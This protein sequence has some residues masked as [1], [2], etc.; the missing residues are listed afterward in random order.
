M[1]KNQKI[2]TIQQQNYLETVYDLSLEA[3]H[4]HVKDIAA[5]LSKSMP[6]VTEAMRKL[7]K[8]GYVNYDIRRNI[9]LTELGIKIG[10]ELAE[11]HNILADFYSKILG[12]PYARAQKIACKVEHVVDKKFCSRLAGFAKF[13]LSC[14]K[15]NRKLVKEFHDYYNRP[16]Y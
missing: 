11:R 14:E 8:K 2:L 13:I 1:N 5:K 15:E 16:N 6:S 12:C 4:T 9:T 7:A 10:K 3:G